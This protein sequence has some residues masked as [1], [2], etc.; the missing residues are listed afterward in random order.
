MKSRTIEE[1]GVQTTP[2]LD[3]RGRGGTGSLGQTFTSFHEGKTERT[4]TDCHAYLLSTGFIQSCNAP[5]HGL[6]LYSVTLY[7]YNEQFLYATI[8]FRGP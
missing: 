7:K 5:R 3:H 2:C 1:A 4:G 6:P 8:I